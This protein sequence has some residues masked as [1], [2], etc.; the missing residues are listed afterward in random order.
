MTS[1]VFPTKWDFLTSTVLFGVDATT[2]ALLLGSENGADPVW[3]CWTDRAL[4]EHQLP[5]GYT[6]RQARASRILPLLPEGTAVRIDPRRPWG[7]A[8]D[9]AALAGLVP[10]C[11]PFPAGCPADLGA[12]D[13]PADLKAA[14]RA[15][16]RERAFVNRIWFFRFRIEDGPAQGCVAV[17]GP[18]GP[19]AWETALHAVTGALDRTFAGSDLDRAFAGVHVLDVAGLPAEVQDW[20][21]EQRAVASSA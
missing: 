19:E 8:F 13:V 15:V 3:V 1:P 12:L 21:V 17:E 14:L 10:L 2:E 7:M 6:L 5:P 11:V 18:E 20:V 4:A 16:V 9:G